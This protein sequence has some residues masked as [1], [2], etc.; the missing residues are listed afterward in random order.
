MIFLSNENYQKISNLL[1]ISKLNLPN[2]KKYQFTFPPPRTNSNKNIRKTISKFPIANTRTWLYRKKSQAWKTRDFISQNY[3][4]AA[5]GTVAGAKR[6]LLAFRILH[7][8]SCLFFHPVPLSSP[9]LSLTVLHQLALFVGDVSLL[10][11]SK[12]SIMAHRAEFARYCAW[13]ANGTHPAHIVLRN[14]IF[15][16]KRGS[17]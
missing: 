11:M 14:F 5:N 10:Q 8:P 9:F 13:C 6:W 4:N 15:S 16:H 3:E 1:K 2:E 12:C 17:K 7:D